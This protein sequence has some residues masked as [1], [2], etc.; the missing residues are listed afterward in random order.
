MQIKTNHAARPILYWYELT[1]AERAELDYL[2]TEEAQQDFQGFR[3]RGNIYDLREFQVIRTRGQ[4]AQGLGHFAHTCE[5]DSPLARWGGI[6]T[7]SYFSGIVVR[8][9]G[10]YESVIVG[11]ATW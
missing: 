10:H 9:A 2:D 11:L 1:E 4:Q 6:L 8:S 3:Y 7:D 5:D